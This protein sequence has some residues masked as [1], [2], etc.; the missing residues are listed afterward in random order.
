MLTRCK[1]H[2]NERRG[3]FSMLL[4]YRLNF[5]AK[6]QRKAKRQRFWWDTFPAELLFT[7][8]VGYTLSQ[9]PKTKNIQF[10]IN[11]VLA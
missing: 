1:E 10:N 7:V 2:L 9:Q 4:R 6:R 3:I 8:I 11:I 5:H